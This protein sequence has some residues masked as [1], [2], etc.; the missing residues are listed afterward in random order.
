MIKK[1]KSLKKKALKS[2]LGFQ[3]MF[4][5]KFLVAWTKTHN[6]RAWLNQVDKKVSFHSAQSGFCNNITIH[7]ENGDV[8]SGNLVNGLR[9][10]IGVYVE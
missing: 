5:M 9:R 1:M 7:Y 3:G 10:G 6:F 2:I 4:S 8:Y